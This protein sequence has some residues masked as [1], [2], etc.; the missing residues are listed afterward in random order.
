M[1]SKKITNP[2]LLMISIGLLFVITPF[3][4][5][6]WVHVSDFVRGGLTGI[7]ISME[8]VGIFRINRR[9]RTETS[10]AK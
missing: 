7:G 8:V 4:L 2:E 10:V 3:L 5:N 6:N 1:N 9:K